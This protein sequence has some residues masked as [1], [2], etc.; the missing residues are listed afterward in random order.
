M[1]YW[2]IIAIILTIYLFVKLDNSI[3]LFI[4]IKV[5]IRSKN[6]SY[7]VLLKEMMFHPVSSRKEVRIFPYLHAD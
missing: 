1:V 4:P 5:K 2:S 7:S 3:E 6:V